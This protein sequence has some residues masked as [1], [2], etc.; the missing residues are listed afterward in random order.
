[1][2]QDTFQDSLFEDP[3]GLRFRH[4]RERMRWSL[5][6]A[7]QQLKLPVAVLDAIEREDWA[8]L[9]APIFVR[10]YLGS[11]ARLL[12]LPPGIADEVVRGTPT[13]QL[14]EIGSLAASRK[15]DRRIGRVAAAAIVLL[16]LLGFAAAFYFGMPGQAPRTGALESAPAISS[17]AAADQ[18]APQ[19]IAQPAPAPAQA[20]IEGSG[21]PV[22]AP[23]AQPGELHLEFRGD[24]WVEVL[25]PD[26]LTIERGLAAAGT[27]RRFAPGQVGQLTLGDASVVGLRVGGVSQDLS[28]VGAAKVARFTVSSDGSIHPAAID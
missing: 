27:E 12:G 6:S 3:I 1:M 15:P 23:S 25:G 8:R 2:S 26:G 17:A 9:G 20:G 10:S 22:S 21:D 7:A 19:A 13:P 28:G 16:V 18:P 4:A 24:S 14:G 5:E 11:Y